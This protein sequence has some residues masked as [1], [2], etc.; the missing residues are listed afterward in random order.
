MEQAACHYYKKAIK[1]LK[2]SGFVKGSIDPCL[3]VKKDSKGIAYVALHIDDNLMIGNMAAIDSTIEA[4]KSKGLV[5]KNVEGLQDYLSCKI[6][7]SKDKK[8]AKL[9]QPI[10]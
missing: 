4:L 6:T 10:E 1:I 9:G 7:F 5:L 2:N 3:Y 8:R